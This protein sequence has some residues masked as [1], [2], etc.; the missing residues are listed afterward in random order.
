MRF[1]LRRP[2]SRPSSSPL[3]AT[4]AA[5]ASCHRI[6]V[7]STAS[8]SYAASAG[9]AAFLP[10]V[11]LNRELARCAR[12]CPVSALARFSRV[13]RAGSPPPDAATFN[14]L[15]QCLCLLGRLAAA[16]RLFDAM[17]GLA[18]GLPSVVSCNTLAKG[19]CL[20]G[21]LTDVLDLLSWMLGA[22]LQPNKRTYSI[23]IDGACGMGYPEL[24]FGFLVSMLRGGLFPSVP[25]YSC[26]L[27]GLCTRGGNLK[28]AL[29]LY[30]RMVKMGVRGNIVSYSGFLNALC[31]TEM[32]TQAEVL[33]GDML[34]AGCPPNV[35]TCTAL[36]KGLCTIGRVH[37]A[38]IVIKHMVNLGIVPN[39][40]TYTTLMSGLCKEGRMGEAV[41]LLARLGDAEQAA[42]LAQEMSKK[43]IELDH[44]GHCILSQGMRRKV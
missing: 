30:G 38:R 25:T 34:V 4:A 36:V 29:V 8:P 9:G 20:G 10:T 35:V 23:I 42:I 19:Y 7:L 5:A 2:H 17:R 26:L 3:P 39:V 16:R 28:Q 12:S 14:V 37:H 18:P 1:S 22:A 44:I 32:V 41:G 40:V 11:R 33:L 43:G 31:R 15:L 6:A 24:G 13:L 27:A 21:R